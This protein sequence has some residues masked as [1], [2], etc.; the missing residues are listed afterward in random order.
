MI[1]LEKAGKIEN[2][3]VAFRESISI[4]PYSSLKR[5]SPYNVFLFQN[6]ED[7]C[8]S[9]VMGSLRFR[10]VTLKGVRVL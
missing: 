10:S 3:K 4:R 6:I 2:G 8:H 9:L 1:V 7:K 5:K